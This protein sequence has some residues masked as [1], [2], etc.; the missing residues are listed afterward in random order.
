M[1]RTIY[2]L[3]ENF[4][5]EKRESFFEKE[6]PYLSEAFEKVY[7]IPL[8]PD[9][10]TLLSSGKNIEVLDFNF[11]QPCNRIR[12]LLSNLLPIT[13][14]WFFELVRTHHKGFYIRKF[15]TNLNDL[16]Y[17][18]SASEKL[19]AL[20]QK[21]INHETVFYSY[22]FMQWMTALSMIK[23][24]HPEMKIVSRVHGADYDEE[25]IKRPL[26][27]RY[28][29]LSKVNRVFPVSAFA[30]NYLAK[31]FKLPAEKA[32]VSRLGLLLNE[33]PAPCDP[34]T[35]HIVSC[36]SLIPLKR[37]HLIVEI[38]KHIPG[39]VKWTHFGDGPTMEDVKKKAAS[40]G[41]KITVDFKGYVS[42]AGFISYLKNQ[43]VSL[44]I[45]VSESEGIPVT[46]MEATSFGIPVAGPAICGV[47]EIVTEQSGYLFPKDFDPKEL[48]T[49]LYS[50][51][52]E[53][54]LYNPAF[55]NGIQ[56]FYKKTFYA[57]LN[58]KK[59]AESLALI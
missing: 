56:E 21:D 44:F 22:W 38:L 23:L 55:R 1:N 16:I 53:K 42:N 57:P 11:F 28:F 41:P 20:V 6:L 52:Q 59:L 48:A 50:K 9:G 10:S 31:R 4:S 12:V 29:Q 26:P 47:P 8:Y 39:E 36:S 54:I 45:N 17:K 37:V 30:K 51:H 49:L 7:V 34:D 40:L 13:R 32:E 15:R 35:F 33:A 18:F 27:F 14:I 46:L 58:Y 19:E 5:N 43:P 24:K 25:Q 2:V 3:A